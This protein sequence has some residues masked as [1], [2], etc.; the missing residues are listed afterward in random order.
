MP[1]QVVLSLWPM[2]PQSMLPA[3][4][5]PP[6]GVLGTPLMGASIADPFGSYLATGMGLPSDM[7]S[8]A[9]GGTVSG[10]VI[11]E[12]QLAAWSSGDG[13]LILGSGGLQGQ[14]LLMGSPLLQG[15]TPLGGSSCTPCVPCPPPPPPTPYDPPDNSEPPCPCS[16]VGLH[17][18]TG[19]VCVTTS[20]GTGSV[21]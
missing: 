10:A 21:Q 9:F 17:T 11:S 2:D 20:S 18:A 19:T 12:E 3:W 4:S 7:Q 16:S 13:D 5:Q 15:V 14:G 8:L 6:V 1:Q